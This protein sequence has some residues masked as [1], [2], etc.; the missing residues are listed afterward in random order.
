MI[1]RHLVVVC[2]HICYI[3]GMKADNIQYTIRNVPA[4]VS[5]YLKK[6]S[7]LTGRSINSIVIEELA[8]SAGL[9]PQS[10]TPDSA[11]GRLQRFFGGGFDAEAAV[12]LDADEKQQKELTRKGWQN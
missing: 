3:V 2:L 5:R 7:Q 9:S 12:R 8:K 6:R 1:G 11:Y 10:T 4:P